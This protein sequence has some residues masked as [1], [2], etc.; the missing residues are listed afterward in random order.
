MS[1]VF[2]MI[3]EEQIPGVF[4]WSDEAV[5]AIMTIQPVAPGHTLVIPRKAIDKWTD[6]PKELLDH[7]MRVAQDI[8]KAQEQAFGVPRAAVV[9]AGF[10]VPHT[11]VHVIPAENE[12]AAS[13]MFAREAKSEDLEAAANKLRAALVE[14]G[15]GDRVPP[16]VTSPSLI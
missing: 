11:H 14:D 16:V 1:T 2:E 5:V 13:L 7:V 4:V 9:I 12:Q 15:H 3:I 6:L 10:E 8:G